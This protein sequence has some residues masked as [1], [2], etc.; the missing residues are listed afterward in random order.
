MKLRGVL[1]AGEHDVEV[2][3]LVVS[4]VNQIKEQPGILL[5][6]LTVA[7]LI[8]NRAGRPHQAIENGCFLS[9][10]PGGGEFVPQLG[11]LNEIGL[12]PPLT[13]FIPK[14]LGQMGLAGSCW[15]N[16]CQVS[17]GIDC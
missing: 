17:V 8:N 11:H 16:E 6:E 12:N 13:A 4:P 10:S 3:F 1:V 15:T 5:V 7:H 2:A 14:G 9:G